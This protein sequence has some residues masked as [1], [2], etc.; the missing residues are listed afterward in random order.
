MKPII[1]FLS[2]FGIKDAYVAQVKAVLLS[3]QPDAA[4]VDITHEVGSFSILSGAW[5][6][7]SSYRYFPQGTI[8][9]AVVDPGVGSGRSCL[10]V[11]KQ[12]H[13]FIGPDNG[14]FSFLYPADEVVRALRRPEPVISNT[15]DG[16]DVFAPLILKLLHGRSVRE[17]GEVTDEFILFDTK[18]PQVVHIDKFGNIITNIRYNKWRAGDCLEIGG[19]STGLVVRTFS[20]IPTGQPA[21]LCGSS[22]TV[23]VSLRQDSAARMLGAYVGMP[24]GIKER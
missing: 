20:D 11:K 18:S 10:I 6:L 2:D 16:R 3:G 5:L 14:I 13:T 21:L 7:Y 8:H 19:C 23:E 15:F 24:V 1:T 22:S 4:I 17:L 9:L 12:G